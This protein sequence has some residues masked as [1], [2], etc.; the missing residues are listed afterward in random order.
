MTIKEP[1]I[2]ENNPLHKILIKVYF[3]DYRVGKVKTILEAEKLKAYNKGVTDYAKT[4][5]ETL[6][7]MDKE[8]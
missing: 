7:R 1:T 5:K 2:D 3:S 6:E 8:L 4:H